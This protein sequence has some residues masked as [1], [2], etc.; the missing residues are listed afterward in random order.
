MME[1][2]VWWAAPKTVRGELRCTCQGLGVLLEIAPGLMRMLR[3]C[4]GNWATHN[5]VRIV[6]VLLKL[7]QTMVYIKIYS[8]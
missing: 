5:K 7:Q 3:L 2:F 8:F 6:H 4:V 1:I